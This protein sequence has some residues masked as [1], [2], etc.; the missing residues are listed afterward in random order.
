VPAS[1]GTPVASW[2]V[3]ACS[4]ASPE[5]RLLESLRNELSLIQGEHGSR[6]GDDMM[7]ATA[8]LTQSVCQTWILP[9]SIVL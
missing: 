6:R 4:S 5:V 3:S 2:F 1:L 9:L 8:K 7:P